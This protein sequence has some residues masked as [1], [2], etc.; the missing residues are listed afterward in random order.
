MMEQEFIATLVYASI[1]DEKEKKELIEKEY[2]YH[3]KYEEKM[4]NE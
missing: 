3:P 1:L 2:K 4:N